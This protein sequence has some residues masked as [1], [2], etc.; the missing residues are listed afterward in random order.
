[1]STPSTR[2]PL[3]VLVTSSRLP[4]ALDV[5]RKV[6]ACGHRIIAADSFK[7]APGSHS[8]YV[9]RALQTAPPRQ[10]PL[11]FVRNLKEAIAEHGV[12]LLVPAFEEVFYISAHLDE[13]RSSASV[14]AAELDT[15][16]RLHDKR[17]FLS[18]S[19]EL[20]ILT[21]RTVMARSQQELRSG[22]AELGTFFARP[23]Y[24]RGGL[25]LMTN[26]G[27]LADVVDLNA[28]HPSHE[29]PWLVQEF[30]QGTDVCTYSM[31]H[32]GRVVAHATYVHPREIE[33]SGG[34]AMES[35]D[36]PEALA[37]TQRIVE[38]IRYN[39]QISLDFIRTDEGLVAIEC[40]PRTTTG[41]MML[42]P[43]QFESALRDEK[44]AGLRVA[45]PGIRRHFKL[46][47]IRDMVMHPEELPADVEELLSGA[48]DVYME[49]NDLRPLF[50]LFVTHGH[51]LLKRRV[52]R[53]H[54]ARAR[55]MAA[56]LHEITWDGDPIP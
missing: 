29:N 52:R 24:S 11:A 26:V 50:W 55:M 16:R 20:G 27:E 35:V 6:G 13:L 14:F 28:C 7:A 45:G 5:I 4:F 49:L 18:L 48:K 19:R 42:S 34:I 36:S 2:N 21:P 33:G 32:H 44:A 41:V 8:K 25:A 3:T 12:D 47:L 37:L 9:T 31:A 54:P 46:G 1:M 43:E 56:Y 22:A 51:M 38:A 30:V 39:G 15:L 23:S 10:E 53:H 17:R 40:N